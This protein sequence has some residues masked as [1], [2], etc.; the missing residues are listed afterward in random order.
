MPEKRKVVVFIGPPGAG[1][2]TQA[3]L[4]R[5][6]KKFNVIVAGD[7]L[8]EAAEKKTELGEK[9]NKLVSA[10]Q[11]VPDET[12]I[13]AVQAAFES[14]QDSSPV[15]IFDGFP[16]TMIQAQGLERILAEKQA[17]LFKVFYFD[18]DA[19]T[20]VERNSN[21]RYC[22]LCKKVYNLRTDKPA[23]VGICGVCGARLIIRE[24]DKP[25][26][27]RDRLLVYEKQTKPLLDYY[28]EK[29]LLVNVNGE[30][31]KIE[32]MRDLEHEIND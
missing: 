18:I 1:K 28:R 21:R 30:K 9:I 2:G 17:D 11:L 26:I 27:I 14:A 12:V 24:D 5:S 16:R 22:P 29:G 10:G 8:R 15:C 4:F 6:K 3:A 25:E 7:I 32:L 23:K 19:E 13:E 20:A 31:E